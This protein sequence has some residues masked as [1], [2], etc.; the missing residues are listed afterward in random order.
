MMALA[1]AEPPVP[2]RPLTVALTPGFCVNFV[3]I[4]KK[5]TL[6]EILKELFLKRKKTA[7]L[8]KR[9]RVVRRGLLFQACLAGAYNKPFF[10]IKG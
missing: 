10:V 9:I 1:A 6:Y 5:N 2:T 3:I 8:L 4:V 7:L